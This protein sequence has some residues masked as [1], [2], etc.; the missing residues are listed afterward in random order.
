MSGLNKQCLRIFHL[1]QIYKKSSTLIAAKAL[2]LYYAMLEKFGVKT[3]FYYRTR[4]NF[5]KHYGY[6]S[7]S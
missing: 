7:I 5:E 1:E 2:D 6:F 3:V 4:E